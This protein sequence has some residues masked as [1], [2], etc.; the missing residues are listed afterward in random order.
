MRCSYHDCNLFCSCFAISDLH[1]SADGTKSSFLVWG[2]S[3]CRA[4]GV[5]HPYP[6][7]CRLLIVPISLSVCPCWLSGVCPCRLSWL[8]VVSDCHVRCWYMFRVVIC[9]MLGV[10]CGDGVSPLPPPG[11]PRPPLRQTGD[12]C[13]HAATT[14]DLSQSGRPS[15]RRL[16]YHTTRPRGLPITKRQQV[17]GLPITVR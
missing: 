12:S 1:T 7:S 4:L 6:C 9:A 10:S 14:I 2:R 15:W 16:G 13:R 5:L 11:R 3:R 8:A 17:T